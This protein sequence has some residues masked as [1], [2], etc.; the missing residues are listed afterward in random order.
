MFYK[1][2]Y[3]FNT[4]YFLG[5]N[6]NMVVFKMSNIGEIT[7]VGVR[8]LKDNEGMVKYRILELLHMETGEKI[9]YFENDFFIQL[10]FGYMIILDKE[11]PTNFI[12]HFRFH[13]IDPE[14]EFTIYHLSVSEGGVV[15]VQLNYGSN[16]H[17]I[18]P[19]VNF[20]VDLKSIT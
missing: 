10:E 11:S 7:I 15:M 20:F 13:N 3:R 5:G 17:R 14:K 19:L 16:N 8:E 18:I 1:R 6:H 4:I 9:S 12:P 2:F